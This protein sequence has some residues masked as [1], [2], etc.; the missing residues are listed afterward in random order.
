MRWQGRRGSG[1]IEDRRG[2]PARRG[3]VG[4]GLGT[5]VLIIAG[6][7]LGVDPLALL[8]VSTAVAPGGAAPAGS[9]EVG[10]PGD[11]MGRFVDVVLADTED[12]WNR[13]FAESGVDY[14]EPRLVLYQGAVRS[15]CGTASAAVGPFYCPVDARVYLDLSFFRQLRDRFGAPGDFAQAYVIAHEIGHHVQN[16]TGTMEGFRGY[17]ESG[18]DSRAV[19]MEL[20]ADCYA[21]IWAHDSQSA[22]YVEPGDLREALRAAAAIGDDNIQRQTRGMVVPESFTHGTSE[23]RAAW[24]LRGYETG[25]PSACDTFSGSI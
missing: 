24:F 6:L 9:G 21:G 13:I 5:L 10:T 23:Q 18:P 3:L 15:A 22:G 12:T 2:I 17:A 14:P 20:Q 4:G 19:R 11:D 7:A 1:N 16:V 25:D 8:Q